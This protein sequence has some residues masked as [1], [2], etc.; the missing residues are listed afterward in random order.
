M[1]RILLAQLYQ[2]HMAAVLAQAAAHLPLGPQGELHLVVVLAAAA[3]EVSQR[4]TRATLLEA[5]AALETTRLAAQR[6][7]PAARQMAVMERLAL[8]LVDAAAVVA[9]LRVPLEL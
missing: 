2:H 6:E 7:Q 1:Q 8:L 4:P 5:L 9:A 3:A